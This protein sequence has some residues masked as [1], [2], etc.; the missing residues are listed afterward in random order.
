MAGKPLKSKDNAKDWASCRKRRG[1]KLL[2]T[3]TLKMTR[4][5]KSTR[6]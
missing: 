3:V 6:K 2:A 5:Q 1:Q 4:Q